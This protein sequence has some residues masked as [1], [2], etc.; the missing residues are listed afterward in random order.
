M[1]NLTTGLKAGLKTLLLGVA[2]AGLLAACGG[3]DDNF[4]DRTGTADPVARF[5][6]AAPAGP[7]FTLQRNGT[8]VPSATNVGYK[9]GSQYSDIGTASTTFSLR[10]ASDGTEL[11]SSN[12]NPDR[13][14]KYT[15]VALPAVT[16]FELMVIDDPYNKG[17]LSDDTRLR[18]LNAAPNAQTF[19][20]YLTATNADLAA[21]TPRYASVAYKEVEPASGADSTDIEDGTYRLRITPAGSK[22][23]IFDTTV[24]VPDNG[25]FLLVV[26]PSGATPVTTNAIQ[27]L[28]VRSDGSA[29]ATDELVNQL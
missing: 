1:I 22:T 10:R 18:A 5:I 24:S 25:D 20:V 23:V 4:D 28:L 11:A 12:F 7:E 29:D 16:G 9:Y 19:D 27:V 8:V 2:T 3:D 21:A 15:V 17:L 6:H 14:H 13:G 26:L